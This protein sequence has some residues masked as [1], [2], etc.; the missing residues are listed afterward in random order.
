MFSV[1]FWTA[2]VCFASAPV[3]SAA[4]WTAAAFPVTS[5]DFGTVAVAAKTEFRF[6]VYNPL[7][8]TMHIQSVRTSCGC[9]TPTVETHYIEPG[10]QGSIHARFNTGSFKGKR[11]A[12][13]TVVIDQPFYS[14]VR[15]K[16][17]GYIRS[18]IVVNPGSI[19]FGKIAQGETATQTAMLYYAGRDSWQIVD[20][21]SNRP[22]LIPSVTEV[23]RGGG[24]V[25][26]ELS[27]T[28]REDASGSFQDEVV[29][30]TNDSAKPR[31]PIR[32]TGEID[33]PLTISPRALALGSMKPG[34]PVSQK[35]VLVGREPFTVSAIQADG[36]D[37]Q[38]APTPSPLKTHVLV[39]QFTPT[40]EK[41]GPQKTQLRI[42]A[43]GSGSITANAI[44]TADVREQ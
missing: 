41:T 15:L 42:I 10:Q 35:L 33:S 8:Q 18:D 14:E 7:N 20:V 21:Q 4:D 28:V 19:D 12:T 22:W 6:P 36:W 34:E 16:V 1:R 38:F 9:T 44:L 27:V 2:I 17:D 23:S 31:V 13:L 29:V 26:Y 5:H 37:I 24:R 39:A 11:G 25:N 30:I 43:A 32:V 3:I 40:G